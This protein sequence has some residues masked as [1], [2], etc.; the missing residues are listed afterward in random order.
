MGEGADLGASEAT[1]LEALAVGFDERN[2][3]FGSHVQGCVGRRR[4]PIKENAPGSRDPGALRTCQSLALELLLGL[5]LQ[6]L[7]AH[8]APQD[9]AV[10]HRR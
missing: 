3:I 6:G 7:S 1:V 9:A 8:G 5:V 4:P 10:R 2:P